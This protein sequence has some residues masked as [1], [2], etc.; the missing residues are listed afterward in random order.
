MDPEPLVREQIDAG[1]RLIHELAQ[2][3]PIKAAFW[4]KPSEDDRWRLWV[5]SDQIRDA[6]IREGY[7]CVVRSSEQ[8]QDPWIS[9]FDVTMANPDDPLVKA[10][11]EASQKNP[12]KVPMLYNGSNLKGVNIEKLYIYPVP[13]PVSP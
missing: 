13:A 3:F 8:L 7:Q 2:S 10:V 1:A 4:V 9:P 12:G 11:I 5:A 6:N